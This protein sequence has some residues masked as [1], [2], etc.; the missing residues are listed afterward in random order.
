MAQCPACGNL[1]NDD[2][3]LV[4]CPS[5]GAGLFIEFDGQVLK[6]EEG[7]LQATPVPP[8]P[9]ELKV[10]AVAEAGEEPPDIGSFSDESEPERSFSV[11]GAADDEPPP[12]PTADDERTAMSNPE[13]AFDHTVVAAPPMVLAE[14]AKVPGGMEDLSDFANSDASAGREGAYH[15]DLYITGIDSSDVRNS[16]KEVLGDQLFL[17]DVEPLLR[18][19]VNGEMKI[20][21]VTAIKA[22]LVVQRMSELPVKVKWVQHALARP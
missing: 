14:P 21:Q 17:W 20:P 1:L 19:I 12:P 22:A 3:G 10:T 4:D 8:D 7:S 5:C 2:F 16:V 11:N 13:I 18:S 9:T 15:Y 6:R